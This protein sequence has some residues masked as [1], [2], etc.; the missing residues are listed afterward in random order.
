MRILIIDP[1]FEA[2]PDVE[3]AVTGPEA[4]IVVWRTAERGPVPTSEFALCDALINCRSRHVVTRE[5]VA[6][7]ERCR[8]V[9]QAGVGFNHIDLVAC[10]ERGIPVCNAPDYGTTEVADHALGLV[11]ALTRGIV[12]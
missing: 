12:A 9:S 10:A 5:I 8:I 11:L 1:Q 6:A 4:E 3:R 2:E 7:M